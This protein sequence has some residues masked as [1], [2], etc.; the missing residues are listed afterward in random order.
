MHSI[1]RT[2]TVNPDAFAPGHPYS[3]DSS[4]RS[5]RVSFLEYRGTGPPSSSFG[6]VGDLYVDLTPGSYAL[7]W[8]DRQSR[9][10]GQW[11]RWTSVLLDKIPLYKFLV[12]HPWCGDA[13]TS[14]IYLWADLS[15]VTWSSRAEICA[16][17]ATMTQKNIATVAPGSKNP[18]VEALVAEILANMI[19]LE[20]HS[21]QHSSS[22]HSGS[23]SPP[24]RL[25]GATSAPGPEKR[26]RSDSSASQTPSPEFSRARVHLP[27]LSTSSIPHRSP[28][29]PPKS[30]VMPSVYPQSSSQSRRTLRHTSPHPVPES[31]QSISADSLHRRTPPAYDYPVAGPSNLPR[32][33]SH[34]HPP[35]NPHPGATEQE[36]R[37]S[38]AWN[39][40]QRAQFAEAHFKRELRQKNRELSKFKKKEKDVI[41]L[42]FMYQKKEQELMAALAS[43][44]QRAQVE[45][46]EQRKAVRILERQV[47]EAEQKTRE[48]V[49]EL[50]LVETAL[51]DARQEILQLKIRTPDSAPQSPKGMSSP[52]DIDSDRTEAENSAPQ[53][54][55]NRVSFARS[56]RPGRF[57]CICDTALRLIACSSRTF[58][59]MTQPCIASELSMWLFSLTCYYDSILIWPCLVC[60]EETTCATHYWTEQ[61]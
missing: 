42:S 28:V 47:E 16:S 52:I 9:A 40:M 3:F 44:E 10:P 54:D 51:A 4:G 26:R 18:D 53:D 12:A 32:E 34:G 6:N 61:L 15:G 43:V 11:Q 31:R 19:A 22:R 59:R 1:R 8:R 29:Q 14:D 37:E 7:Y 39:E 49:R 13:Q 46:E 2:F 38:F 21:T 30:P 17:R 58:R 24:A 23:G 33:H 45:L 20:E 36:L 35:L 48:A 41:S 56:E 57:L 50:H 60:R 55:M 27:P 25:L 5:C